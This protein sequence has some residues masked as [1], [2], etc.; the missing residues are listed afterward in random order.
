M[1]DC[2]DGSAQ[3]VT[4]KDLL[5]F[6]TGSDREPPLGFMK[7]AQLFFNHDS[8]AKYATASTCDLH[9]CVPITEDYS[10]FK[11]MMLDSLLLYA[12]FGTA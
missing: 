7:T 5:I 2:D 11:Q 8:V 3:E 9:L 10:H 4:G 1:V 12:G 6:I